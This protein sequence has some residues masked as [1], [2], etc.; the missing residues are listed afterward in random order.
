MNKERLLG[1]T[2]VF[3]LIIRKIYYSENR[4]VKRIVCYFINKTEKREAFHIPVDD[5]KWVNVK[6]HINSL[7]IRQGDLLIVH[8]SAEEL[9]NIG[10]NPKEVLEYLFDLVGE[11]GTLAIPCFPLYDEKNYNKDWD[12][13]VYN[14]FLTFLSG[15]EE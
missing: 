9:S 4:F 15:Q 8:S 5:S 7:N 2:P 12:M 11:E 13:Y 6:N 14:Y 1:I 3:E 10:V